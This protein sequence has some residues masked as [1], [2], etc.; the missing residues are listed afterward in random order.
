MGAT[1]IAKTKKPGRPAAKPAKGRAAIAKTAIK[2][3]APA[4]RKDK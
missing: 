4:K 1:K 3:K 2:R